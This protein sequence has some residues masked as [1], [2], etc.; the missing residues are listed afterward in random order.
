MTM[1]SQS[2]PW[3]WQRSSEPSSFSSTGSSVCCPHVVDT[4][5]WIALLGAV[6]LATFF[7][8]LAIVNNISRRRKRR[9][10]L[11]HEGRFL[12]WG[13]RAGG[14]WLAADERFKYHW[15]RSRFVSNAG[16]SAC[17]WPAGAPWGSVV[18]LVG[19]RQA[20]GSILISRRQQRA[21]AVRQ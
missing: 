20:G 6:V 11:L 16:S 2:H 8:R 5:T 19:V 3:I 4:Y 7:L 1:V 21:S 18:V 15:V 17:S 10:L 13:S 14:L 9:D 12:I